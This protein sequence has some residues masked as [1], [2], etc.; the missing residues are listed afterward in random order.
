MYCK[1][2][3]HKLD[4]DARFCTACGASA[5]AIADETTDAANQPSEMPESAM[6]TEPMFM[7]SADSSDSTTS[8][9]AMMDETKA[10]SKSRIPRT[11]LIAVIALALAVGAAFAAY[12]IYTA[13]DKVS[14]DQVRG[15][16]EGTSYYIN[17]I[18]QSA[19]VDTGE[20]EGSYQWVNFSLDGQED[21]PVTIDNGNTEINARRVDFSGTIENDYFTT[22]FKGQAYYRKSNGNWVCM[23]YPGIM[24]YDKTSTPRKGVDQF[25]QALPS[26]Y[27]LGKFSSTL[28]EAG[29]I[30]TS[31]ASQDRIYDFW[32]ATDTVTYTQT[33]IFDNEKGWMSQSTIQHDEGTTEWKLAGKTFE[34]SYTGNAGT[35]ESSLSFTESNDSA[36][37]ANYKIDYYPP[38][39]YESNEIYYELHIPEGDALGQVSGEPEHTIGFNLF[40]FDLVDSENNVTFI[41]SNSINENSTISV[42]IKTDRLFHQYTSGGGQ[43]LLDDTQWYTTLMYRDFTEVS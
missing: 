15:D 36:I 39:E 23:E 34:H 11:V 21:E 7:E 8:F 38:N 14:E 17:G 42:R 37:V 10:R 33:F 25:S 24:V 30:Y 16:F 6:A 35:V 4:D 27:T 5:D 1:Q 40:S 43:Y 13:N 31:V 29:D 9:S 28:D 22:E 3:G 2:C 18:M 12:V 19:Y 41:C 20:G 26:D 32:F